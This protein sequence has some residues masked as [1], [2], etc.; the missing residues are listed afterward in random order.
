MADEWYCEIAGREIGPLSAQQLR[1]MAAKGQ[2][3]SNDCVRQGVEGSW[4]LARQVRGLLPPSPDLPRPKP[5]SFQPPEPDTLPVAQR[6]SEAPAAPTS[7]PPVVPQRAREAIMYIGL[8]GGVGEISFDD[9]KLSAV[10]K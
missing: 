9:I 7:P 2:I 1:A 8:L 6:L 5:P 10:K 3:L 4:I